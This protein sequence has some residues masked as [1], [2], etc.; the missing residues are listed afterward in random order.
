MKTRKTLKVL[1]AGALLVSAVGLASCGEDGTTTITTAAPTVE[2]TVQPTVAPTTQGIDLSSLI[3]T[4]DGG[5]ANAD[6]SLPTVFYGKTITWSSS[7]ESV[8]TVTESGIAVIYRP[9][10]ATTVTLTANVEGSKKDFT[11]FV[12]PVDAQ[13]IADNYTFAYNKKVLNSGEYDLEAEFT[14]ELK[15][16]I[17]TMNLY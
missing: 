13:E 5:V 11:I 14:Y 9:A 15:N 16:T 3:L 10:E 12:N 4:Q 1:L 7:H 2:P 6:F 17:S 8:L